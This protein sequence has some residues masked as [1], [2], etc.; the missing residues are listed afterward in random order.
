MKGD[1][2]EIDEMWTFIGTKEEQAWLWLAVSYQTRQIVGMALGKRDLATAQR[3]WN[4]LPHSYWKKTV[5]TDLYTVY[6]A[7]IGEWQHRPCAKG[8]GRTNT[9]E[10]VN[11]TLRQRVS[12]LVRKTLSFARCPKRLWQR[13]RW[14]I[15]GYNKSREQIYTKQT[16]LNA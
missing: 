16:T 13:L 12:P 9:V 8:E 1:S 2:L 5:Y 6:P 4:D 3:L 14:F 10:R 7:L 11:C 15:E